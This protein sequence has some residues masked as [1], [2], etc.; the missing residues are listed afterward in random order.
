MWFASAPFLVST[1]PNVPAIFMF[2]ATMFFCCIVGAWLGLGKNHLR[3]LLAIVTPVLLGFGVT[4]AI[5]LR[6]EERA[7]F[8]WMFCGATVLAA[9][10]TFLLRVAKGD[11][12][13]VEPDE[14]TTDALQ[15]GIRDLL[16]W[17][18][19][20]AVVVAILK[21]ILG[22]EFR[23]Y[24]QQFTMIVVVSVSFSL[25][26]VIDIWAIHGKQLTPTKVLVVFVMTCCA[27]LANYF[28]ITRFKWFFPSVF[29]LGQ[30][31]AVAMMLSFRVRGY[32]FVKRVRSQ[33]SDP[34]IDAENASGT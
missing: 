20:L 11:Y 13:Q 15:F 27:M 26:T 9:L 19:V 34:T 33:P 30:A 25:A 28:A 2:G 22:V 17:T 32:R 7:V 4:L 31:L 3:W 5:G 6:N 24:S 18:A 23:I 14:S 29:L 10:T 1:N 8:T 21:A 12:K 16:I